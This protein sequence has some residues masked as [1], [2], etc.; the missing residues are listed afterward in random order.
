[1][2]VT[3]GF[4]NCLHAL[5]RDVHLLERPSKA[6]LGDLE[7]T[8]LLN[9]VTPVS[10]G[11]ECIGFKTFFDIFSDSSRNWPG[12][13]PRAEF[14]NGRISICMKLFDNFYASGHFYSSDIADLFP[15]E[16]L[17]YTTAVSIPE[18]DHQEVVPFGVRPFNALDFDN[19]LLSLF[20]FLWLC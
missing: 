16:S 3:I 5:I 13:S 11:V 19:L 9:S 20:D 4:Y 15:S 8:F 12:S 10:K 17:L 18:L 1:M 6:I 7:S 2:N 14:S